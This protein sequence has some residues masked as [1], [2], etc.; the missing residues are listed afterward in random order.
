V[1][2]LPNSISHTSSTRGALHSGKLHIHAAANRMQLNC[3]A[4][5]ARRRCIVPT[6]GASLRLPV[7]VRLHSCGSR[8][9]RSCIAAVRSCSAVM[10]T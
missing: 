7:Q 8:S 2:A 4:G 10:M 3:G 9:S 5:V 1:R 6:A